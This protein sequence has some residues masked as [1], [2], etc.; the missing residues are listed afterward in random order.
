MIFTIKIID[1][2]YFASL[3][4]QSIIIT[5][6]TINSKIKIEYIIVNQLKNE[7]SLKR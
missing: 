2:T 3:F 6:Y 7:H 1:I 4:S 5:N